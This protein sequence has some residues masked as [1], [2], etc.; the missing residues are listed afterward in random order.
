MKNISKFHRAGILFL[1]A[2]ALSIC[3]PGCPSKSKT[4]TTLSGQISIPA[5]ETLK[6]VS[7][8]AMLKSKEAAS[9]P[10]DAVTGKFL[11]KLPGPGT[12]DL[13]LKTPKGNLDF[14]SGVTAQEG[15]DAS[16]GVFPAPVDLFL[17]PLATEE[18]RP[19]GPVA[20]VKGHVHPSE[21]QVRI[22]SGNKV[23]AQGK[24]RGGSFVIPSVPTGV[25][26]V[27]YSAP[28]YTNAYQQNVPVAE[29]GSLQNLNGYLLYVSPV[30]GVDWQT[31]NVRATGLGKPNP[32]MPAPQAELMACQAAKTVAYRNML[33]TLLQ[34]Q[35]APG[36]SIKNMGQGNV[37]SN[38]N[39]FVQ[40]AR[41]IGESKRD[42]GTCVI[43]LEI[44]IQGNSGI[45]SF[46]QKNIGK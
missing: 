40:G 1:T 39:G 45:I 16:A 35:V 4:P 26:D 11:I 36:K 30:D 46:I 23:V 12:Y 20:T 3:M 9:A 44:P 42:D 18:V 13:R 8:A 32:G 7:V 21:A 33:N 31:E 17:K 2:F 37:Q 29:D 10:V 22:M 19:G 41:L 5:G 6:D 34:V 15:L 43:T 24:A 38:L 28:G 27:E 25:Y 14:A